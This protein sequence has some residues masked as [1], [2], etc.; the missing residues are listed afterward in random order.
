MGFS[1]QEYWSGVPLPSPH[2]HDNRAKISGIPVPWEHC[3]FRHL[4]THST[5]RSTQNNLPILDEPQSS[6]LTA[7]LSP[8]WSYP[9]RNVCLIC[10]LLQ[11]KDFFLSFCGLQKFILLVKFRSSATRWRSTLTGI[12][13]KQ[14]D[15][16]LQIAIDQK[17]LFSENTT[18]DLSGVSLTLYSMLCNVVVPWRADD[19]WVDQVSVH[20]QM[21]AMWNRPSIHHANKKKSEHSH[22]YHFCLALLKPYGKRNT[23]ISFYI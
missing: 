5:V 20:D 15:Q 18:L 1:R 9:Y 23:I 2:C 17:T 11:E 10:F 7:L 21:F 22:S 19:T 8:I 4:A 14:M 12:K 6:K 13:W 16:V 3:L